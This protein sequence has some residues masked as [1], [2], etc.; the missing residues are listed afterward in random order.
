MTY[1]ETVPVHLFVL[2]PG[3]RSIGLPRIFIGEQ[4]FLSG[5]GQVQ[6]KNPKD[7]LRFSDTRSLFLDRRCIFGGDRSSFSETSQVQI[8]FFFWT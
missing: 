2:F 7:T 3:A 4:S 6:Q 1:C 8:F 5:N